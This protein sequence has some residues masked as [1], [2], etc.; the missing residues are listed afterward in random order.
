MVSGVFMH[1]KIGESALK[2]MCRCALGVQLSSIHFGASYFLN[3]FSVGGSLLFPVNYLVSLSLLR[4]LPG[5]GVMY[6]ACSRGPAVGFY[7]ADRADAAPGHALGTL[8]FFHSE[9]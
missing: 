2:H 6:V 4:S 9:A 3:C 1:V 7:E 5:N 8:V